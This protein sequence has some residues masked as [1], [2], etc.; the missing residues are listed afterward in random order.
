MAASVKRASWSVAGLSGSSPKASPIWARSSCR[1]W[2]RMRP[3]TAC[4]SP[5]SAAGGCAARTMSRRRKWGCR[6]RARTAPASTVA[7]CSSGRPARRSH[8]GQVGEEAVSAPL[9]DGQQDSLLG[10]EVVV[11]GTQR[12]PASSTTRATVA[13]S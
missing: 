8:R 7:R 1:A 5:S 3:M 6:S 4:T 10:T 9:H 13:A 11:D 12:M 2:P